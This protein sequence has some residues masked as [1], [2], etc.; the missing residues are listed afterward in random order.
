MLEWNEP[1]LGFYRALGARCRDDSRVHRLSGAPLLALAGIAA[2]DPSGA[3]TP[4]AH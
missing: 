4:P 1:A 2:N 3:A